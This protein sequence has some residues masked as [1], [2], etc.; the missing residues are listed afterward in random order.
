[1]PKGIPLLVAQHQAAPLRRGQRL[2]SRRRQYP[3][4]VPLGNRLGRTLHLT[5]ARQHLARAVSVLPA[6]VQAHPG[7]LPRR[8]DLGHH[9]RELLRPV[10]VP[11]HQARQV[12]L[13]ER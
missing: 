3:V 11:V 1:M 10:C 2:P 13:A 7:Q 9:R 12:L 5:L 8:R 4:R 6:P